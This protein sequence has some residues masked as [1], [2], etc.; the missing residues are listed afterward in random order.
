MQSDNS[1]G[2][3]GIAATKMPKGSPIETMRKITNCVQRR[4]RGKCDVGDDKEPGKLEKG[5][6]REP[7]GVKCAHFQVLMT[8]L[9]RQEKRKKAVMHG[10]RRGESRYCL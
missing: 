6:T 3:Q 9:E 7:K 10:S 2:A 4:F 1:N 8:N 5:F